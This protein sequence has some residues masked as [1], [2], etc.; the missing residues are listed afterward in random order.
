[1]AAVRFVGAPHSHTAAC[2]LIDRGFVHGR[3]KDGC[4]SIDR[5]ILGQR[6]QTLLRRRSVSPEARVFATV[7]MSLQDLR[8]KADYDPQVVVQRS[9]AV[10]A[11]DKS[12]VAA[13][14]LAAIE[15]VELADILALL[16]VEL[17]A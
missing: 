7:F 10:D 15:P 6:Q 16:L 4:R 2:A 3:M 12:E 1:M 11:C 17:R 13:Q 14:A 5:P 8:H 9:D